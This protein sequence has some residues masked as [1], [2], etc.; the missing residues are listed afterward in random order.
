MLSSGLAHAAGIEWRARRSTLH[1]L[2][3]IG[4][5]AICGAISTVQL[6]S[7]Q[8]DTMPGAPQHLAY[9]FL[10]APVLL[11]PIIAHWLVD[12]FAGLTTTVTTRLRRTRLAWTIGLLALML[13]SASIVAMIARTSDALAVTCEN[14]LLAFALL[15]GLRPF[16]APEWAALIVIGYG[17]VGLFAPD[18]GLLMINREPRVTDAVMGIGLTGVELWLIAC[19]NPLAWRRASTAA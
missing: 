2:A 13:L 5:V 19:G 14:T 8:E 18:L 12:P 15:V 16:L 4:A 11:A 7:F 3:L 17:T 9:G 10:Y 6:P 1:L